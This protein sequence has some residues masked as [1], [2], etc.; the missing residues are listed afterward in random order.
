M[1]LFFWVTATANNTIGVSSTQGHPGDEVDVK[2][3]LSGNETPTA[4][5]VQIAL[6]KA[7]QYVEGSATLNAERSNGHSLTAAAKDGQLSIVIYSP[8]LARLQGTSG[9]LCSFRL[10]L[11]KEPASYT[12]NP[13]VLMSD[14]KGNTI[15]ATASAGT[16]T[17]LSPKI[18]V[19]TPTIDFGHIP[20]RQAYT[21]YLG[22]RNTGNEPL[23]VSA[24]TT[25]RTDL[26]VKEQNHTVEPGST[27]QVELTYSPTVR[28][29]ME[30]IVSI[31]S[32]AV[33]PRAGTTKVVADPFSVN[34]LHVQRAEGVSD[35]EVT[36]VLK[37]NNMEPIAGAQ[38][39]FD[40]PDE[41]VYV[42]G[43]ATAGSR[44]SETGHTA[45]GVVEG[46]Q[47]TLL[48][49]SSNNA[50]LP[51]GDGELMTFRV[52][53]NGRSGW[54]RLS[55][56]EVLLSNVGM[57]NMVSAT[58]GEY[59]II[60]SPT[61]QGGKTLSFGN[62]PVTQKATATY[63]IRNNGGV[64]LT[65]SKVTFLAE[66]YGVED[67][68]PLTVAPY[69]S[70]NI[71]VT[72]TPTKE[73]EHKTTMQVYTNDPEN[74]MFSVGVDGTVYEPNCIT[75]DGSNTDEGY[76]L[77]FG[78]E[79]YTDI[80]AVQM[81][82]SWLPGMST[83]S[84]RLIPTERLKGHSY[85]LTDMGG[86]S[87][88]ILVYSMSNKPIS[89]NSGDLFTLD[90]VAVEGT[91]FRDTEIRVTDIV[92][93][94][95]RGQNY[96][97]EHTAVATARFSSYTLTYLV[98]GETFHSEKLSSGAEIP[99]IN[100]PQKE[101]YVFG[102]WNGLPQ[103]M[104]NGDVVVTGSFIRLGDLNRDGKILV[105]D[106]VMLV[107]VLLGG[108]SDNI[109]SK[110]SDINGDGHVLVN[111]VVMLV[112]ILL[113]PNSAHVRTAPRGNRTGEA[114]TLSGESRKGGFILSVSNAVDYTAIQFDMLVPEGVDIS[115]IEKRIGA[116]HTVMSGKIGENTVRVVLASMSNR[117]FRGD[118]LLEVVAESAAEAEI[119][120]TNVCM[121]TREGLVNRPEGISVRVPG[122]TTGI[123]TQPDGNTTFDVYDTNGRLVKKGASP[124][125]R[126]P[127][128]VYVINGKKVVVK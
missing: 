123:G 21:Q 78:M 91:E 128:G 111:D 44:C 85:L 2:V 108:G 4:V 125:D 11:G 121:S 18:E 1:A 52:R 51:E 47:L 32:N 15:Q 80:V 88:Q 64:D 43:S 61:F 76:R 22:L 96:A 100:E 19:V 104:P 118:E 55:P 113:N 94:N 10:K 29:A 87:Y 71:T 30:T 39:S 60:K 50:A 99:G 63:S 6:D 16:V 3:T 20:I 95:A 86:G 58:S 38:C 116:G 73:G 98:D 97:S 24:I 25:D 5:E 31:A 65:V 14:G 117:N 115:R 57:E 107:N 28:G 34:E 74:R 109:T 127:S 26:A 37:M 122:N 49:Y 41:L 82:V 83:S 54:Y 70:R 36:V 110:L 72:Y 93:S 77:S 79:N 46:K 13:T 105:N 59:V 119:Q 56:E 120:I 48:L 92:L 33:N 23:V 9:E 62:I 68:F 7:L 35:E 69:E 81:N 45:T 89:G 75:V 90:Y 40:L 12:L 53:L 8:T 102:G 17:L 66:G 126:L 103:T 42:E 112:N 67:T 114:E 27:K 101:G 84:A 124:T 106:V